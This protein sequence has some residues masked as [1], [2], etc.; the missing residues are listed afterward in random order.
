MKLVQYIKQNYLLCGIM[1][2]A[3]FL[4]LFHLNFQSMVPDEMSTMIHSNPQISLQELM[5]NVDSNEGFP[6]F[7]FVLM[8]FFHMITYTP[9][10]TRLFSAIMG[11]LSVYYIY[12]LG[13]ELLNKNTGLVA[14]LLLTVNE[15]SIV[16]SQDSRP[17][18]LI[19]LATILSFY[20][21]T[22]L[23]K[24]PTMRNAIWYG[25]FTG[26]LVNTS[27]FGT[28]TVFS[29]YLVLLFCLIIATKNEKL[30]LFKYYFI[31]GIIIL[32]LFVPNYRKLSTLVALDSTWIP[33]PTENSL[34]EFFK[35]ILG[36]SE[37]GNL[38]FVAL[39]TFYIVKIFNI[40]PIKEKSNILKDNALLG[41]VIC[42]SWVVVFIV[43]M[44]V[45]S[46][47]GL[48]VMV[49]RYLIS[50]LPAV[51][52]VFAMGISFIRNKLV[53]GTAV[54]VIVVALLINMVIFRGY[55]TTQSKTQYR[56]LAQVITTNVKPN[57]TVY[58]SLAIWVN[59]FLPDDYKAKVYQKSSLDEVIR[60]MMNN[61]SQ[62]KTFWY[63]NADQGEYMI[64]PEN[65]EF[66]NKTFRIENDYSGFNVWAKH[67]VLR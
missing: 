11:I 62:I 1:L 57:E 24:T 50:V 15:F 38:I 22:I 31:S 46:I 16:T 48:S 63:V 42:T 41:F 17:Y 3:A 54:F 23:I 39:F 44:Y 67:F 29:Q 10:V 32:L 26:L 45:K 34:S 47:V 20:R 61:S 27:F 52:I 8:R 9:I 36:T 66:V 56:E 2:L 6:Y 49:H 64:A 37:I 55:Y 33:K 18:A 40:K 12:R 30:S 53:Q 4:R 21:L 14:A 19:V 7:Y 13:K 5:L 35:G 58:T 43:I 65:L 28:I 59:F 60:E 51:L 25:V